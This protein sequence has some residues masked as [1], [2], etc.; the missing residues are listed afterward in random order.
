MKFDL[1]VSGMLAVAAL[2]FM[3]P[4]AAQDYKA[5]VNYP[6][7]D[8]TTTNDW[9]RRGPCGDPWVS[10][11]LTRVH[12]AADAARCNVS[13]YNGGRWNNFNDLVHAVARQKGAGGGHAAAPKPTLDL[14]LVKYQCAQA[15]NNCTIFSQEGDKVGLLRDGNFAPDMPQRLVAAGGGNF[16]GQ[17]GGTVSLVGNDGA[18]LVAAGSLNLISQKVMNARVAPMAGYA[19]QGVNDFRALADRTRQK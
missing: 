15:N 9:R 10:I 7:P 8:T 17:D 14:R 12:G 16:V 1:M 4:A 11:A 19:L 5:N 3:G 2:G 18:G 6:D 13:L